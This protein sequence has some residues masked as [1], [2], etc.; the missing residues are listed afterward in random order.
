MNIV[1]TMAAA[2][3]RGSRSMQLLGIPST[4]I[5]AVWPLVEPMLAAACR[6][7]RDKDAPEDVHRA[8]KGGE[9]QLWLAWEN[10]VVALAVTEI[11]LHSRKTCCRIRF[12]T[13]RDRR[14]WQPAIAA[15]ER[16][17]K[18]NG[19]GAMELIARPGWS[20]FLR[21]HGYATTHFFCEKEL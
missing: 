21:H 12:C 4:D 16:W 7:G 15:I 3:P 6:R 10:A 8:L 1:A 5:D 14:S 11:V 2:D 17:A 20:R 19:C 18:A 13:G 9:M